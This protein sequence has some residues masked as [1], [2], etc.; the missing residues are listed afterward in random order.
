[1]PWSDLAP[2]TYM[3]QDVVPFLASSNLNELSQEQ[4]CTL[5]NGSQF[6]DVLG[7]ALQAVDLYYVG[8]NSKFEQWKI[9]GACVKS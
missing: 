8:S 7:L 1:M 2:A 6:C 4:R 3:I 9:C 5:G